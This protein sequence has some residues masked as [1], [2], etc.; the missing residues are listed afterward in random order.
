MIGL[1]SSVAKSVQNELM[2]GREWQH[3]L[4]VRDN[5]TVSPKLTV[6]LGLRWE[7]YPIMT[8]ADGRG[9]ERLDLQTLE[10]ILGGRGGNPKNVGLEPGS[11]TS[12][13]ASAASTV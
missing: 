3:A 10:V 5:W 1:T 6:N 7:Y 13:R 11:I 4:Y 9:L 12:R 2:T 8:R